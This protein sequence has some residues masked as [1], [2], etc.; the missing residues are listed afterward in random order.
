MATNTAF[1]AAQPQLDGTNSSPSASVHGEKTQGSKDVEKHG[2]IYAGVDEVIDRVDAGAT[3]VA[4]ARQVH[5]INRVLNE[6]IGMGRFQWSLFMLS[7]LGESL[8]E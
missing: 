7:G 2:E 5:I 8:T 1:E 6:H 4:Y 3:D